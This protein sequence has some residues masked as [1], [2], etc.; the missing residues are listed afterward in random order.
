MKK[1]YLLLGFLLLLLPFKILLA[2]YRYIFKVFDETGF[3]RF[4][5]ELRGAIGKYLPGKRMKADV[6]KIF[7]PIEMKI[8]KS[9]KS[10]D[11]VNGILLAGVVLYQRLG[12]S[13]FF[14]TLLSVPQV[15]IARVTGNASSFPQNHGY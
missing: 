3:A 2:Q 14:H 12:I 5:R 10:T 1:H 13:K 15:Q 6:T 11:Y 4:K 8:I 9:G 7:T